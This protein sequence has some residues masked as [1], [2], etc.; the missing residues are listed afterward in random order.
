MKINKYI[1]NLEAERKELRDKYKEMQLSTDK[2]LKTGID[3]LFEEKNN[4][5]KKLIET[6]EKLIFL[7]NLRKAIIDNELKNRKRK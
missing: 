1:N 2:N 3:P 4:T 5:R 7:K 6:T